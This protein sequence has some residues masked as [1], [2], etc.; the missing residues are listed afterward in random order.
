MVQTSALLVEVRKWVKSPR[1]SRD[2]RMNM[3]NKGD[4]EIAMS[5]K[6][7]KKMQEGD[8]MDKM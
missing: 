6:V 8:C 1:E 7:R 4:T 2:N 3:E 5:E